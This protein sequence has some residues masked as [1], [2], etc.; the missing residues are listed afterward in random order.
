MPHSTILYAEDDVMLRSAVTEL[1]EDAG[2]SV[3]ACPDGNAAMN[4]IAGGFSYDLL[5]FD[6]ELPGATGVEL[7]RYARSLPRYRGTPIIVL[8]AGAHEAEARGAGADEFL[9]KPEDV[10]RLVG[11]VASL[12]AAKRGV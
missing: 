3:D 2:W 11:V 12:V 10:S 8:S 1:L 6:N 5:L 7:T 4:R 9:R